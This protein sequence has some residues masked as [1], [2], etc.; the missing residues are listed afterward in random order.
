VVDSLHKTKELRLEIKDALPASDLDRFGELLDA[1]WQNKK[2]RSTKI[3]DP[4]IDRWYE[5]A[6]DNGALGGKLIGAGGGGFL[7]FYCPN[8]HKGQLRRAMAEE[9]LREMPF[10][11]D[12]EGAKVLVDF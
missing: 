5:I 3:T 1:H 6:R 4:R 11:F 8:S 9:G 12:L 7:L 10:D 2:R